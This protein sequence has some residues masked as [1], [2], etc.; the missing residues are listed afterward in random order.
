MPAGPSGAG[1]NAT[2][3]CGHQRQAQQDQVDAETE[4]ANDADDVEFGGLR[5]RDLEAGATTLSSLKNSL[6]AGGGGE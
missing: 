3:R 2:R 4:S 6:T 1:G 5:R